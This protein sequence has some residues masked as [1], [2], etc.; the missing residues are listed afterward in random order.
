MIVYCLNKIESFKFDV[1][2]EK[3]IYLLF[4]NFGEKI[5]KYSYIIKIE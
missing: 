2:D 4:Q 3:Y 1:F 5:E